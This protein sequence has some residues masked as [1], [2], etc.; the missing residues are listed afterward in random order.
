MHL[1]LLGAF[2]LV[3]NKHCDNGLVVLRLTAGGIDVVKTYATGQTQNATSPQSCVA[4]SGDNNRV[5]LCHQE[6]SVTTLT[7]MREAAKTASAGSTKEEGE[8]AASLLSGHDNG[9]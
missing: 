8:L 4:V 6:G 5:V 9:R 1:D 3:A 7:V 2:I